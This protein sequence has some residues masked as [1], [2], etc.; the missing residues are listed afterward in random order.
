MRQATHDPQAING[1]TTTSPRSLSITIEGADDLV[2]ERERE[3]RSR[4]RPLEDMK[5]GSTQ[6]DEVDLDPDLPRW[7]FG[8]LARLDHEPVRRAEDEG[9]ACRHGT[10]T[11]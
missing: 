2:P 1:S 3:S 5:V 6:P 7:R 9:G 8:E 11:G 10:I 4:V